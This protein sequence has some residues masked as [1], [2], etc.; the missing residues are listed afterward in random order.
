VWTPKRVLLLASGFVVFF[1]A[2][3]GYA[4]V[5]GGID[6][7]PALPPALEPREPNGI[8]PVGQGPSSVVERLQQA[9]GAGCPELKMPI[10]IE[11]RGAVI[12]SRDCLFETGGRTVRLTPVS[13]AL[14]KPNGKGEPEINTIRAA[15]ATLILDQ[16]INGPFD[17]AR[18]RIV[19]AELHGTGEPNDGDDRAVDRVLRF[20]LTEKSLKALR[21][22][23]VPDPVLAKLTPLKDREIAPSQ[24]REIAPRALFLAELGQVLGD[25]GDEAT[26]ELIVRKAAIYEPI[27]MRNNRR[28]L[29]QDD[30][31][32]IRIPTGPVYFDDEKHLIHTKDVV[33]LQDFQSKPDPTKVTATGMDVHLTAPPSGDKGSKTKPGPEGAGTSVERIVLPAD[34]DMHLYNEPGTGLVGGIGGNPARPPAAGPPRPGT[35]AKDHIWITTAGP[36]VYDLPRDNAR[37]DIPE[38]AGLLAPEWVTVHRNPPTDPVAEDRSDTLECQHLELQFCRKPP[39]RPAGNTP[40][41]APDTGPADSHQLEWM[42]AS[43]N[44]VTLLSRSERVEAKGN[45]LF[46]RAPTHTTVLKGGPA[47]LDK[48]DEK[49]G[50]D[51][52]RIVAPELE[53]I[54][55][56]EHGT[57]HVTARGAGSI[58]MADSDTGRQTRHARWQT[59]FESAREGALDVLTFTGHAALVEDE[60]LAPEDIFSDDKL[61]AC[62]SVLK[63]DDLQIWLD[64]PPQPTGPTKPAAAAPPPTSGPDPRTGGRKPRR[65]EATGHVVAHSPEMRILERSDSATQRLI[66]VFKDVPA[67]PVPATGGPAKPS[68]SV[69]GPAAEPHSPPPGPEPIPVPAKP[70]T[71]EPAKPARPVDLCA[72]FITAHVLRYEGTGKTELDHLETEGKVRATQAPSGD[73][74]GFTVNGE[75]LELVKKAIGNHLKVTSDASNLADLH[76]DRMIIHGPEIEIDQGDNTATVDGDG[77]MEMEN[78]TD[79]QGNPLK[80]PEWLTV[81]WKKLMRF[82]G[83]FAEFLGDIEANQGSSRLKCQMLQVYFDK[84][85]SLSDQRTTGKKERAKGEEPA[86]AKKL[87][88]DRS[89][90]VEE[91]IY[92]V[93]FRL[94]EASMTELRTAGVPDPV[95]ARLSPLKEKVFETR[96]NFSGELARLLT[97]SELDRYESLV[98]SH[99]TFQPEPR[100][101]AGF[102][103]LDCLELAVENLERTMS[104][105]GP[106]VVRII[107]PGGLGAP[108]GEA[109]PKPPAK[110]GKPAE[111]EWALTLVTYGRFGNP[112]GKNQASAGR[113]DADNNTHTA[114]FYEDVQVLHIPWSSDPEK[115]R[116]LVNITQKLGD[117]PPGGLYME[118]RDKLKIYSPDEGPVAAPRLDGGGKH[119]MTGIGRVYVK[120]IDAKGQLFWGSAEEV[121]FDEA[122]DQLIFDGKDGLAEV[123]Q[124]ERRG[125]EP[126]KFKGRKITYWRKD[127]RVDSDAVEIRGGSR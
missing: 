125:D 85:V 95:L 33:L 10:Q 127:G 60:L 12:A 51:G 91:E 122:K 79:F 48:R 50:R 58:H 39:E 72:A 44:K 54:E 69:P 68:P 80:K 47:T 115:L 76:V 64:P 66:I 2:Y 120:S 49:A 34:V 82:E 123:Y 57:Q 22:A 71:P 108:G 55:D 81:Y 9:F 126:K 114:I 16:P 13:M 38:K 109:G 90:K 23:G 92:E 89:V 11:S 42:H 8:L 37:F 119:V 24:D 110:P 78:T 99:A 84:P 61:V 112:L 94:G 97:R 4:Q 56:K 105:V 52:D 98:V 20:K 27:V 106:G 121:H 88:C 70:V 7:L 53:L 3:T 111:P 41:P 103:S 30:D 62:K 32:E 118:C 102:K 75:K 107:Q 35:P 87:I 96:E 17:M 74:K 124:V 63:S 36:F 101:L 100:R 86:R 1:A 45:D 28:T 116:I 25:E 14:F 104:A 59:Q 43:G 113:M 26:R 73:D 67:P 29:R 21:E 15:T 65:V 18:R 6:G 83:S 77:Y 5:L 19:A 117:L 31:I 46:H 40:P 93:R